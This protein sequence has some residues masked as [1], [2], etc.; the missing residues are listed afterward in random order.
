MKKKVLAV[1]MAG[2]IGMGML[3]GCGTVHLKSQK[4]SQRQGMKPLNSH[5]G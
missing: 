5:F 3:A 1:L 2:V 4:V